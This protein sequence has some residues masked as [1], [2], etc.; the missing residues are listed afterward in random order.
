MVSDLLLEAA[1][2]MLIGMVAVFTF[3]FALVMLLKLMSKVLQRYFP[4][5]QTE[6]PTKIE[7][8][9]TT[10][11]SPAIVAAISAAIH[12]YRKE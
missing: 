11:V 4:V 5:K 6:K 10:A 1:N 3:L 9:E 7:Q 8:G 2:L 12:Q